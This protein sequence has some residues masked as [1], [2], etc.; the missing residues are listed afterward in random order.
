MKA[1]THK[2][3]RPGLPSPTTHVAVDASGDKVLSAL[4]IV[5]LKCFQVINQ[6]FLLG[7]WIVRTGE[8]MDY[9]QF[10]I[11]SEKRFNL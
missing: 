7:E 1:K 9:T 3:G 2:F 8:G 5:E 11:R 10:S 4:G 6:E